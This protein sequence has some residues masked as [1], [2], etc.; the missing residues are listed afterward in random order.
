MPRKKTVLMSVTC[1]EPDT[2][3]HFNKP[4]L[5][6][7][8]SDTKLEESLSESLNKT[9]QSDSS[10]KK[11]LSSILKTKSKNNIYYFDDVM[12]FVEEVNPTCKIKSSD[13]YIY[14]IIDYMSHKSTFFTFKETLSEVSKKIK[15]KYVKLNYDGVNEKIVYDE[16][17][18]A[19]IIT[20]MTPE[21]HDVSIA[22]V[23][24]NGEED[25]CLI[26]VPY[27]LC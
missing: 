7:I 2:L 15:N 10:N 21:T 23:K 16:N 22:Q 13:K 6:I 20:R 5:N 11:K 27:K 19:N 12:F 4:F 18:L 9:L 14:N 26:I 3:H 8:C 25:N 17:E 1:V 24:G